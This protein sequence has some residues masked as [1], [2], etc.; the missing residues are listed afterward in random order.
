[1]SSHVLSDVEQ[2]CD[3]VSIM[4]N[5]AIEGV[6]DLSDIRSLTHGHYELVI[7]N[8]DESVLNSL[9]SANET[10]SLDH[11]IRLHYPNKNIAHAALEKSIEMKAEIGSFSFVHGGLEELFVKLV[12]SPSTTEDS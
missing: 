1:M 10:A 5:G 9:P 6:F 8:P 2:L 3:R 7:Q 4:K 12:Q 11:A